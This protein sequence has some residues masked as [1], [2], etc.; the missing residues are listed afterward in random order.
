VSLN[1]FSRDKDWVKTFIN[2]L[3]DIFWNENQIFC[4]VSLSLGQLF[5][6][7]RGVLPTHSLDE[8]SLHLL[9]DALNDSEISLGKS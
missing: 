2:I 3:L 9:V 5:S 1:D 4:F 6:L 8:H 7:S